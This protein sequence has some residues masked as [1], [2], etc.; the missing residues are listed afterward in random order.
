MGLTDRVI[1]SIVLLLVFVFPV[2]ASEGTKFTVY[3]QVFDTGGTAINGVTV[4]LSVSDYSINAITTNAT[5]SDGTQV[6]GYYYLDLVN[7]PVGVDAGTSMTLTASSG[8]A[9]ASS[10]VARAA[11]DPQQVDLSLSTGGG[12]SPGGG[13]GGGGGGPTGEAYENIVKKESREEFVARN[14]PARYVFTQPELP[15]SQIEITSTINAGMI[16]VIIE[17]LKGRSTF[18]QKD[19]PGTVYRYVNIWVGTS[20]FARP[21]NIKEAKIHFKIENS[22]L[23]SEGLKDVDIALW[24]W[25]G[26]QWLELETDPQ[27]RDDTFTY[28]QAIT[29]A[30]SPF[31]IAT[32]SRSAAGTGPAYIT[33]T[34]TEPPGTFASLTSGSWQG[35]GL[36]LLIL[37]LAGVAAYFYY[38]QMRKEL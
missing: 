20:G 19:A 24:R 18:A 22:W 17:L 23:S 3:G 8:G 38:F 35:I 33:P 34:V 32:K 28:Y 11:D 29:N 36:I 9:S 37:I 25:D 21:E 10:T 7:L 1:I 12:G 16:N 4:Y 14:L 27:N 2:H 13:G 30:F 5:K 15:V 31:A 6:P 26:A